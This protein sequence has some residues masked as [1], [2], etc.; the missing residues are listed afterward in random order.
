MNEAGVL[1]VKMYKENFKIVSFLYSQ[2]AA[3]FL[4]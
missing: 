2:I 4:V 3:K 1:L